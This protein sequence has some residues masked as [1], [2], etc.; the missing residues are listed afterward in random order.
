M[1]VHICQSWET[2][3]GSDLILQPTISI[4]LFK[5]RCNFSQVWETERNCK[6]TCTW[7][8]G[9]GSGRV[10]YSAGFK[11][12]LETLSTER[13]KLVFVLFGIYRTV[14]VLSDKDHVAIHDYQSP[15]FLPGSLRRRW[16]G[17]RI[18]RPF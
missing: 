12:D 2:I 7:P 8:L 4:D 17:H 11:I 9:G 14:Q 6:N 13:F 18:Y 3:D 16:D 5:T 10:Q 1:W 15:G